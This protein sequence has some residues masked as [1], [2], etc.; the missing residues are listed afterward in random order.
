MKPENTKKMKDFLDHMKKQEIKIVA[1]DFTLKKIDY[2]IIIDRLGKKDTKIQ[3]SSMKLTFIKKRNN[4]RL[5]TEGNSQE[6]FCKIE[7]LRIFFE[8]DVKKIG[9]LFSYIFT[10]FINTLPEE[11]QIIE[12]DKK[13][14][15]LKYINKKENEENKI[16]PISLKRNQKEEEGIQHTRSA[17]NLEKTRLLNFELY[18]D[19]KGDNTISFCYTDIKENEKTNLEIIENFMKKERKFK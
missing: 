19:F 9:D 18:E 4:D 3:Y 2:F 6:L 11:I 16:Y 17:Y 14:I 12:N 7:K 13:E 1:I 5:V 15:I 8:F 10:A